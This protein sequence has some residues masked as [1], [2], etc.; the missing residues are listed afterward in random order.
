LSQKVA[1]VPKPAGGG[2]RLT[3]PKALANTA[4]GDMAQH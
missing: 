3:T 1:S 4:N 2:E